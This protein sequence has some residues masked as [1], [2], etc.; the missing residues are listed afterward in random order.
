[1][2][3]IFVIIALAG[4]ACL[5]ALAWVFVFKVR[6]GAKRIKRRIHIVSCLLVQGPRHAPL[7]S[8]TLLMPRTLQRSAR[9]QLLQDVIDLRKRLR[10]APT[11]GTVSIVVTDIQGG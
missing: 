4:A 11:G 3:W 2:P 7:T 8:Y 1:M 10:G 9:P 5:V 6:G